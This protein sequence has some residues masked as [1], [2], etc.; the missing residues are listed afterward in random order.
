MILA[1]QQRMGALTFV[2][3]LAAGSP[4]TQ[5]TTFERLGLETLATLSTHVVR[6]QV[7]SAESVWNEDKSAIYTRARLRVD[8]AIAGKVPGK[9]IVV[10]VPGGRVGDTI[11]TVIGAPTLET[12]KDMVLMLSTADSSGFGVVGL[13]QGAFN[14]KRDPA[15]G[16]TLAI[17]QATEFLPPIAAEETARSPT[18]AEG[19]LLEELVRTVQEVK[20]QTAA[21]AAPGEGQEAEGREEAGSAEKEGEE[22]KADPT[23]QEERSEERSDEPAVESR[24]AQ[25]EREQ[26]EERAKPK[27][28][29]DEEEGKP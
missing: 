9:E 20:R 8:E 23:A 25:A 28:Q 3:L 29:D 21:A 16:K 18:G 27:A 22:G 12:G 14:L 26:P 24:A 10:F 6:G 13:S 15:S 5:A 19:I 7:L 4:P 2:L 17:S 11:Q 1:T